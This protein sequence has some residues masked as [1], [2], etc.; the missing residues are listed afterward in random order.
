LRKSS[1]LV[2]AESSAP[3][4]PPASSKATHIKL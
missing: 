1:L 3:S 2:Q 4:N